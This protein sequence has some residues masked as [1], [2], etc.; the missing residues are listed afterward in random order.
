MSEERDVWDSARKMMERYGDDALRQV[1]L[2]IQ[3]LESHGQPE[4]RRYWLEIE[5]AV[6]ALLASEA[7][8]RRH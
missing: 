7:A 4:A 6:K 8:G 5:K 2:R 1:G 3:E